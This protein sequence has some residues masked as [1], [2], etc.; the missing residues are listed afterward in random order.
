MLQT[1]RIWCRSS[2]TCLFSHFMLD[3]CL[4]GH[5]PLEFGTKLGKGV[6]CYLRDHLINEAQGGFNDRLFP[7]GDLELLGCR[8]TRW[9]LLIFGVG[10]LGNFYLSFAARTRR[11]RRT[12][13]PL[14]L[15]K[16]TRAVMCNRNKML[17]RFHLLSSNVPNR[18]AQPPPKNDHYRW[19][20]GVPLHIRGT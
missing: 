4:I 10:N 6:S 19:P 3:R 11:T 8:T 12:F 9:P 1:C 15:V 16:Q 7:E 20:V 2:R 14:L 5:E 13:S 17:E 18:P